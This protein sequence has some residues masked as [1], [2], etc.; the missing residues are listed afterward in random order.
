MP[1]RPIM[2]PVPA[3]E[4]TPEAELRDVIDA[5][6]PDLGDISFTAL[7]LPQVVDW[8]EEQEY[9]VMLRVRLNSKTERDG[10]TAADFSILSADS[11]EPEAPPAE[12]PEA[13]L[14]GE[15]P[16]PPV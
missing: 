11:A 13:P 10:V 6:A 14:P 4:P 1:D 5:P 7:D 8:E 3:E 2:P 16:M 12:M 15:G 9:D